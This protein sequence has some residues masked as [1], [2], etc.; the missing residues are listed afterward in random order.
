MNAV[1]RTERTRYSELREKL[2]G[3]VDEVS[4]LEDGYTFPLRPGG[5]GFEA[6]A[7]WIGYERKCCPF[8][9]F[10]TG[11]ERGRLLLRVTGEE[12]VEEFVRA[13]FWRLFL[14]RTTGNQDNACGGPREK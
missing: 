5:I 12:G 7:E 2:E 9:V 11:T 1:T 10:L 3:A 4:E 6:I 13:E 14:R 8:L